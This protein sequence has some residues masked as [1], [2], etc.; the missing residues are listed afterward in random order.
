MH[1]HNAD[2][3]Q[4]TFG[5]Y[6][7]TDLLMPSGCTPFRRTLTAHAA[8]SVALQRDKLRSA[9]KLTKSDFDIRSD[10]DEKGTTAA[11]VALQANLV[12]ST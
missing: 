4:H 12:L 5:E 3:Q 8:Y 2:L 10:Y 1:R 11:W 6:D 7:G 9:L